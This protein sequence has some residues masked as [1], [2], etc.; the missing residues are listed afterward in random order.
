MRDYRRNNGLCFKCGDKYDPTH[1]CNKKHGAELHATAL[2]EQAELLSEEVLNLMELQDLAQA[3]QLKLS[4]HAMAG[5]EGAETLKLRAM[6]GNQVLLIL[7]DSGSSTSFINSS[8]VDR[9]KC[10]V[11]PTAP[12]S[13]KVVNGEF[14][15]CTTIVPD[16]SWWCQGETFTTSMRVLELGAYDAILGIDWLK[17]HSPMV[18]D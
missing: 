5:T 8:M 12:V 2:E 4:I 9:L 7:V 14:M 11:Q 17:Q 15:Q 13:V 1:Q 6:V 10:S 3:K 16:F 18:T